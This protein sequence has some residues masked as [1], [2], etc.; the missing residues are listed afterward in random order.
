MIS[1]INPSLIWWQ[2]TLKSSSTWIR[3][4][5]Q[6]NLVVLNYFLFY[7]FGW[8]MVCEFYLLI[9]RCMND[10]P[11][12]E[13]RK[14]VSQFFS[15]VSLFQIGLSRTYLYALLVYCVLFYTILFF[16]LESQKRILT[17]SCRVFRHVDPCYYFWLL[18]CYYG[19]PVKRNEV[20]LTHPLWNIVYHYSYPQIK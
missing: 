11:K 19:K 20:T 9:Q 17:N 5:S 7:S 14:F 2:Y 16:V 18:D 4:F 1:Q 3:N 10:I 6:R 15:A 12:M 8:Y 13:N